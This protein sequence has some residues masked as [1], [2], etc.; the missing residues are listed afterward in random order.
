MKIE[1]DRYVR[2]LADRMHNGMVKVVTGAR[3]V[4]KSYLLF[5][6]F[7]DYLLAQGVERSNYRRSTQDRHIS[8][9]VGHLPESHRPA[10]CRYQVGIGSTGQMSWR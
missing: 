6:L 5:T 4:G 10:Y 2:A 3:R 1:R 7:R 9:T 8:C